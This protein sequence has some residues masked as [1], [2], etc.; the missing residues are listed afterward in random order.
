LLDKRFNL[1]KSFSTHV[2]RNKYNTFLCRYLVSL[3]YKEEVLLY[4]LVIK[5]GAISIVEVRLVNID[6]I[7]L[8][9]VGYVCIVQA[10]AARGSTCS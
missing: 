7:N 10:R 3:K 6:V 2:T 1:G 8:N 4:K 5:L 9:S